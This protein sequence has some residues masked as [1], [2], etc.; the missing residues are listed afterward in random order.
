[1][2]LKVTYSQLRFDEILVHSWENN[3]GNLFVKKSVLKIIGCDNVIFYICRGGSRLPSPDI[4]G[5][6]C[7]EL[8]EPTTSIS[9]LNSLP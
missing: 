9:R 8:T 7:R 4:G 1:M 2:S 5:W 6:L 3:I